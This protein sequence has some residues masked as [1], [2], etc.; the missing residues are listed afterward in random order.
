V[1]HDP[2]IGR[3]AEVRLRMSDGRIE[4]TLHARVAS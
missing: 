4:N 2:Q 1:T 3:R